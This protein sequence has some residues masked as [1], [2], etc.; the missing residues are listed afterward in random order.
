MKTPRQV[1]LDR[2]QSAEAKLEVIRAEDLAA[3]ARAAAAPA[4][5]PSV[6]AWGAAAALRRCWQESFRPWRWAWAGMA[7]I[8]LVLW[9]VNVTTREA[10]RMARRQTPRPNP[11]LQAA[12]REQRELMSRLF[13]PVDASPASQPAP[14]GPRSERRTIFMV[15]GAY[16]PYAIGGG[17]AQSSTLLYRRVPPC[18]VNNEIGCRANSCT[19]EVLA[20]SRVQ[21]GDTAECNSALLL[22]VPERAGPCRYSG[23]LG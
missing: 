17:V 6:G 10:P 4:A 2:H 21:L 8:W 15:A 23:A 22:P 13:D 9:A 12:L 18:W 1:I 5:R 7:A 3:C 19:S 11:G 14:P 20:L 16:S